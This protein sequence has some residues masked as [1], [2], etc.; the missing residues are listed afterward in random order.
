SIFSINSKYLREQ[1]FRHKWNDNNIDVS[2]KELVKTK[3]EIEST[4]SWFTQHRI[5]KWLNKNIRKETNWKWSQEVWQNSKITD[6]KTSTRDNS[7]RSFSI[8]LLNEELPTMKVL[9]TRKPE[10]YKDKKCPFCNIYDE[11][12]T[13][14]FMCKDTPNTLKNTFC[15]ILK[16]VFTQE[17]GKKT[18]PNMLKK[19]YNSHFLQVDIGR[20]I[21]DTLPV[22]RF[23]YNDLVK[24]LIPRSIY[25][26]VKNYINQAAITKTVILKTFYKWKEILRSTWIM[27]CKEFLK[28][29]ISN[30]INEIKKKSKGKRPFDDFE[31]LELK[32]QLVQWGKKISIE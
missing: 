31:Y 30:E 1:Q 4:I 5:Y 3:G 23:A 19:I 6:N 14:V 28:W 2:V 22:D 7:L 20:Q 27:R 13:H 12:N 24:G 10:I 21:R 17:T 11:T 16:K 32:K 25:N 15:Y 29:E 8:K 18:D 26:I 9:H